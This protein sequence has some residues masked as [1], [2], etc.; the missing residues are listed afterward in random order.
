MAVGSPAPTRAMAA[1]RT[2]TLYCR[3]GSRRAK[4]NK[5]SD[6]RTDRRLSN[7]NL[8]RVRAWLVRLRCNRAG[9]ACSSHP[10]G[11]QDNQVGLFFDGG[12]RI[13]LCLDVVVD[14]PS[15]LKTFGDFHRVGVAA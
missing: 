10:A 2:S 8:H 14:R 5:L 3:N 9:R 12:Q 7:Q 6:S 1:V 4:K 15:S 13:R 11:L